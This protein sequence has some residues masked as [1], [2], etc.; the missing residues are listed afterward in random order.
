MAA[1]GIARLCDDDLLGDAGAD[2][3]VKR[4]D[5]VDVPR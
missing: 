2:L 1:V 3:V 4:L 5:A